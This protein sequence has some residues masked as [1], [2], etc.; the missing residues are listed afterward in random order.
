ML[1]RVPAVRQ[2]PAVRPFFRVM[3]EARR[4]SL[5]YLIEVNLLEFGQD[6][7][8]A[9]LNEI[10]NVRTRLDK[11]IRH[12]A[13]LPFEER[14]VLVLA[15][16]LHDL[17]KPA[18]NHGSLGADALDAVLDGMGLRLPAREVGRLRWL[19]RHHLDIRPLMTKMGAEGE[20]ALAG[21]TAE[22]GDPT[23]VSALI[24]F[25]FA[26]R[27]AVHFDLNSN[28]HDAAVLGDMLERVQAMRPAPA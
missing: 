6:T 4:N 23:L 22:A 21:F 8:I 20:A 10:E 15:G 1:E 9:A 13:A 3:E 26:D 25:T 19:I 24:L 27:M 17:K 12:Y 28:A 14:R 18:Q 16:L 5:E 2:H 11:L 7:S